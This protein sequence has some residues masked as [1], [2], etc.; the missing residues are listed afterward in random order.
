MERDIPILP[1]DDPRVAKEFSIN[2]LG[3]KVRFE[4]TED[5]RVGLIVLMKTAP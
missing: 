5:C 3:F 2:R 1:A 4:V